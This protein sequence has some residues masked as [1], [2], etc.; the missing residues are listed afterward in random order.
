LNKG[1]PIAVDPFAGHQ[2]TDEK[3]ARSDQKKV[4]VSQPH[5]EIAADGKRKALIVMHLL[6]SS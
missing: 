3:E 1:T 2:T 6:R 5:D 4:A